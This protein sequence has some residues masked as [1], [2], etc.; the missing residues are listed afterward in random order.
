M[1]VFK[2][3]TD[4]GL[5]Q[6]TRLRYRIARQVLPNNLDRH[7]T[8]KGGTLAGK[9]H[10]SHPAHINAPDQVVVAECTPFVLLLLAC[11]GILFVHPFEDQ[12]IYRPP[13]EP[14]LRGFQVLREAGHA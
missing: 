14:S 10:L 13:D 7:L 2:M 3:R 1:L 4:L 8:I 11:Q 12:K 6:K 9:I 5:A